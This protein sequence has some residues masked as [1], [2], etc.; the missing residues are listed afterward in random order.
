MTS[1]KNLAWYLNRPPLF[2][3]QKNQSSEGFSYFCDVNDR[4]KEV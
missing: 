2:Y 1:I 4:I 3:T